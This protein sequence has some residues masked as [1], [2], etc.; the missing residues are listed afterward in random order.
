LKIDYAIERA[1]PATD[2]AV[3]WKRIDNLEHESV[4]GTS[5]THTQDEVVFGR[6]VVSLTQQQP[7]GVLG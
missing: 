3:A 7:H 1:G 5:L 6:Y 4:R 2:F